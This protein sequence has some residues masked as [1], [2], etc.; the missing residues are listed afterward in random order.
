VV[1]TQPPVSAWLPSGSRIGD[2]FGSTHVDSTSQ[3]LGPYAELLESRP[4]Q[5]V[6]VQTKDLEQVFVVRSLR[7]LPQGPE[8]QWLF[9]P[10]GPRRLT[11]VTCAPPFDPEQGG[12]QDLAVVT[13][14]PVAEPRRKS[15]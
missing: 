1:V 13:A 5:R 15:Q 12:Y 4:G 10:A 7:L 8:R 14:T 6:S 3:G 9:S 2:P 11:L